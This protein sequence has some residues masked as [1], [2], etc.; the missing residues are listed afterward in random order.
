[1]SFQLSA[2]VVLFS[3]WGLIKTFPALP[4]PSVALSTPLLHCTRPICN[5]VLTQLLT[6][7]QETV[8]HLELRF[9]RTT[10]ISPQ[11]IHATRE[12]EEGDRQQ[13]GLETW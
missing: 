7:S 8:R 1:V 6:V 12:S 5:A 11:L 3:R 2:T 4:L 13:G 10:N 9:N